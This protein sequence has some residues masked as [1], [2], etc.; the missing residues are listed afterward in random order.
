MSE[1]NGALVLAT[2]K[3]TLARLLPQILP[4]SARAVTLEATGWLVTIR[5]FLGGPI[6]DDVAYDTLERELEPILMDLPALE[7]EEWQLHLMLVRQD[8]PRAV[9]ALGTIIWSNPSTTVESL[10]P[11]DG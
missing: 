9:R 4:P 1:M 5:V 11:P 3:P 10:N 6:G 7:G 2:L 8:P